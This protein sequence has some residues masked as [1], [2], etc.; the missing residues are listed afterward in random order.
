MVSYHSYAKIEKDGTTEESSADISGQLGQQA[1]HD[2]F[3]TSPNVFWKVAD[4][5]ERA[6]GRTYREYRIAVPLDTRRL[7]LGEGN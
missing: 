4:K 2:A 5:Y 3:G 1:R 7:L 6:S